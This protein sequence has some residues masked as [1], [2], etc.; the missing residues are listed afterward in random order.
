VTF[1]DHTVDPAILY[2]ALGL[3]AATIGSFIA[4]R[5]CGIDR[6]WALP[7]KPDPRS[8]VRPL[9][10]AATVYRATGPSGLVAVAA[11]SDH[12]LLRFALRQII[13]GHSA[14]AVRNAV[15]V[16]LA[17]L[18]AVDSRCQFVGRILGQLAPALGITGMAGAM[19]L[20]LSRLQDPTGSVAGLAIGVMMLMIGGNLIAFFSRRLSRAMPRATTAGQLGGALI[21]EASAMIRRGAMPAEIERRMLVLLGET[22]ASG[23]LAQA[24]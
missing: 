3:G 13:E 1:K 23:E 17:A 9:T 4:A 8:L 24:A 7:D 14:D 20:G 16:R 22:P 2:L 12:P 11:A 21:V 6:L 19:Y 5:L 10:Q 15:S 18:H